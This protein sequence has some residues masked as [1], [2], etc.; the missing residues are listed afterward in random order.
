MSKY[1]AYNTYTEWERMRMNPVVNWKWSYQY[2]LMA[3]NI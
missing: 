3:F 1:T 2:E